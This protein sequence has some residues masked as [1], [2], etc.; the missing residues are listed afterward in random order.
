MDHV[1]TEL[2]GIVVDEMRD[3]A[4]VGSTDVSGGAR[5]RS[6]HAAIAVES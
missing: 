2:V 5:P 3:E 1:E 4:F 6:S